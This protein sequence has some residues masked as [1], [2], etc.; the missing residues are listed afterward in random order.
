MYLRD[1]QVRLSPIAVLPS[2]FSWDSVRGAMHAVVEHYLFQLPRR[3]VKLGDA[4]KVCIQLGPRPAIGIFSHSDSGIFSDG[5]GWIWLSSFDFARL[6]RADKTEQQQM[7]LDAVHEGLM[8][9][10]EST[11]SEIDPFIR[12]KATLLAHPL[13][14]PEFSE[15]ELLI[16]RGLAPKEKKK[17]KGGASDSRA[18]RTV[19]VKAKAEQS[20]EREPPMARDLES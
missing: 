2:G 11:Q 6:A 14:L 4:A 5:V 20:G 19:E 3:K 1:L 18:T 17:R 15:Q 13:P 7:F 10:A 16:R 12:A 9:I 8:A